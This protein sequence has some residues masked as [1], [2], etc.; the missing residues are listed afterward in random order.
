VPGNLKAANLVVRTDP[1]AVPE[2]YEHVR[3]T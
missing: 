2:L 3:R 1:V